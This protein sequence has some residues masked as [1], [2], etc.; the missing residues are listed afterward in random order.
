MLRLFAQLHRSSEIQLF[1]GE[2]LERIDLQPEP[3]LEGGG[4]SGGP[5]NHEKVE[6]ITKFCFSKSLNRSPCKILH[7]AIVI[8]KKHL[9]VS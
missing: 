5:K 1:D 4:E 2:A 9:G 3:R 6:K 8:A 7:G